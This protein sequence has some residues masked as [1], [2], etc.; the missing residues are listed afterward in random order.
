MGLEDIFVYCVL[1]LMIFLLFIFPLILTA[2]NFYYMFKLEGKWKSAA[3][4]LTWFMGPLFS[5]FLFSVSDIGG[6]WQ[7]QLYASDGLRLHTPVSGHY[8]VTVLVFFCLGILGYGLLRMGTKMIPPLVKVLA[9]A[10]LY[11][12][13]TVSVL[14]IAQMACGNGLMIYMGLFPLNFIVMSAGLIRKV[15]KEQ[16]E[17]DAKEEYEKLTGIRRLVSESANWPAAAFLVMWP[18]MGVCIAV[19][20][21]F[22]QEPS[23]F[24][25][26]FTETSDWALSQRVSPPTIYLDGHYLCTVA[27]GGHEKLVKPQRMGV[28]HGHRIVVNRQL[29]IANAFEEILEERTPEFHRFVRH[30][31]D[32]YGYPVAHHIKT[33][34]AADVTYLVM[35]PLEW[36]FL[37]VLYLV[38]RKPEERIAR[39]Y[40]TFRGI[41]DNLKSRIK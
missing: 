26:A 11:M 21:L 13:F 7:E 18:V 17:E 20:A 5:A 3:E 1:I 38:D 27:A 16:R 28:R 15:V 34:L 14:W 36:I 40:L 31:Y 6:E 25:K 30:I 37:M 8:V 10:F 9:I 24:I 4:V 23:S 41:S 19:L 33:P 12:G 39:Q 2:M 29:C 32:T 22:G 35:K